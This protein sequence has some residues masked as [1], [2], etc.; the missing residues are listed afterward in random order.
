MV[1]VI[2]LDKFIKQGVE[3]R[4][5]KRVG[6]VIE[7]LGTNSS[8][9]ARLVINESKL[10]VIDNEVAPLY[11]TESN[12]LGPLNLGDEKYVVP[13]NTKFYMEG[14]SGSKCRLIGKTVILSPGEGFPGDLM[15]RFGEQDR[16]YRRKVEGSV[17]LGTDEAWKDDQELE[18][19]SITPLTTEKIT[20]NNIIMVS[21]SGG[22]VSEGDFGV[23]FYL[24]NTPLETEVASNLGEG[25]DVLAM[26]YPPKDSVNQIAFTLEDMPIEVRGDHTLSIKVKNISGADKSPTSGSAWSVTLKA[27]VKYEKAE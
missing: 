24:D 7:A 13:P 20:F 26:P 21:I 16:I 18:V 10:G 3:Y 12:L 14:D 17:S 4:T 2:K 27:I 5:T 11:V 6:Y 25:I 15:T 22:T 19:Y 8:G 1:K 23:R 9:D